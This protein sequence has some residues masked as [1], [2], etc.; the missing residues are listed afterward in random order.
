MGILFESGKV[1][2]IMVDK[3]RAYLNDNQSVPPVVA[4]KSNF[5]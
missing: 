2:E 5:T 3:V 1:D 4:G